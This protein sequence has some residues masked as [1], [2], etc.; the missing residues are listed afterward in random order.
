MIKRKIKRG[1]IFIGVLLFLSGMI[2]I[3]ELNR[4]NSSTSQLL[5]ASKGNIELSKQLLDAVQQQNTFLLLTITDSTGNY[6]SDMVA[7]RDRFSSTLDEIKLASDNSPRLTKSITEIENAAEDYNSAVRNMVAAQRSTNWFVEVYG[8]KYNDLTV[9]IK[10]YMIGYEND[11][12]DSARSVEGNALRAS[13]IGVIALIAAMLLV[14]L[15]YFLLRGFFIAPVLKIDHSLKRYIERGIPFSAKIES[16]DEI[17]SL[18]ENITII[19]DRCKRN[20]K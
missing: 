10:D 11:L 12:I 6:K 13:M 19:V 3:W 14:V 17:F 2:S 7:T 1:F 16:K 20:V 8:T 5:S 18:Y 9:A 15:F 4:L